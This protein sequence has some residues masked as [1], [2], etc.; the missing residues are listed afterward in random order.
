MDIVQPT[1]LVSLFLLYRNNQVSPNLPYTAKNVP[2]NEIVSPQEMGE[3]YPCGKYI[4]SVFFYSCYNNGSM[5]N[6]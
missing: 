3:Y 2:I 4:N 1:P 5:K 6:D